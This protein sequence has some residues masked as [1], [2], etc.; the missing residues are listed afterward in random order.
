VFENLTD[1][2]TNVFNKLKGKG[3]IDENSLNEALREIRI[4]LLES[5]VSIK[6]A[7][8]FIERVKQKALGKEV[9]KSVSPSQMVVKIVNDELTSLLGSES[10]EINLKSKPPAI[11][12]MVGLQGS[13]KTTTSAKLAKWIEKNKNKKVLMASLDIYRPAAQEQLLTLGA[14]NTIAVLPKQDKKKPLDIAKIAKKHAEDNDFDVLILDSAGRNHVDKKMMLEI[15]EISKFSSFTEIFF[16]SDSLTGQDAVN[17][18]TSFSEK[19]DLTGIILTRLD[20]DGRGGAALSMKETINRPIKFIGVGEKIDDFEVFHPDR[21]ANRILGMGDVVSLVEKASEQIDKEDAEKLQKKI[22]KGKFS[23]VDYSKQLDQLTNMGGIQ[24]FLKYLPGMSGLK[25][26]V[27]QS[28]E[29]SDIF[30]KQK[31]IISSM[32]KKE[33]NFPDIVKAS[34]KIRIS[35]GSGTSVQ[36]INKL[37]KQFKKMSQMMKKMGKNKNLENMM[38][39]GQMGDLQSLLNKNKF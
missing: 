3:I 18:A 36:D 20:G 23:L 4:A 9:I 10:Y 37:L 22:L 13:G 25:E 33:K 26:K 30:K 15:Q 5:D 38:S 27:E 12:L 7:K 19:V 16:I 2:I 32:T 28:M 29:N 17:T 6:V 8:D 34:R 39:S 11:M 14:D 24:G 31:A 21:I 35:K 1:K